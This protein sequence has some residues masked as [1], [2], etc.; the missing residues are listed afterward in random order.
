MNMEK[1]NVRDL[2]LV[3][4]TTYPCCTTRDRVVALW[5]LSLSRPGAEQ[6]RISN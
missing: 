5:Q 1:G 2:L 6:N 4:P 3:G